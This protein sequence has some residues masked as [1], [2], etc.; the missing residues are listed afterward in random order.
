VAE[1]PSSGFFVFGA[2]AAGEW[3]DATW[4]CPKPE[5]S[6]CA[7]DLGEQV[8]VRNRE[9]LGHKMSQLFER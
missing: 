3:R 6:F 7:F 4:H 1:N 9:N 8:C 5:A 2:M